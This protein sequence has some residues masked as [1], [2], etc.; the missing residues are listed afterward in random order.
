MLLA[1]P[2]SQA[3]TP[4]QASI[5]STKRAEHPTQQNQQ[6]PSTSQF[7]R[8]TTNNQYVNPMAILAQGKGSIGYNPYTKPMTGKCF[9]CN[10]PSHRSNECPT[11]RSV[12]IIEGD[13]SNPQEEDSE[14]EE[15]GELVKWDEGE[16]VNCVVQGL[17]LAP[18][19]EDNTQKQSIFKTRCTSNHKVC[20]LI[21]DSGSCENIV[22]KALVTTLQLKTEKHPHP[23]KIGWIKKGVETRVSILCRIPYS[24]GKFY[25][26]EVTC[27][28]VEMDARHLLLGRPWQYD[29]N[30]TYMGRENVYTFWWH[31]RK[32]VLLPVEDKGSNS[33][34]TEEKKTYL[35]LP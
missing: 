23:Y 33:R 22:S 12:N 14:T 34:A 4:P 27:D 3:R 5:P 6:L 28:V 10:Q 25:K 17:L 30:A 24:I 32:V 29:V 2:P 7:Q 31:D 26:D 13:E 11:C 21:I 1:R 35:V 9:R 8:N 20:N 18:K 19:Q 15:E 16:F